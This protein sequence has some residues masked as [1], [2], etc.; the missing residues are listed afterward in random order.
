MYPRVVEERAQVLAPVREREY[1][2]PVDAVVLAALMPAAVGRPDGLEL[3]DDPVD[4][5]GQQPRKGQESERPEL[6]HLVF[7]QRLLGLHDILL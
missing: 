2:G 1:R 5:V 4:A 7:G 6:L 3:L